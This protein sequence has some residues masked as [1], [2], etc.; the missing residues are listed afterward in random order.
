MSGECVG[1]SEALI[2]SETTFWR[3]SSRVALALC[4]VVNRI[5]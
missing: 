1:H 2:K 5:W 4:D 3:K